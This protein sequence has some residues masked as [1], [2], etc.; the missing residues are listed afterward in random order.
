MVLGAALLAAGGVAE[1]SSLWRQLPLAA[2]HGQ[3]APAIAR[4]QL[5]A[6]W[7]VVLA[8]GRPATL[9]LRL[10]EPGLLKGI[11]LRLGRLPAGVTGRIAVSADGRR[12]DT[13]YY[14]AGP[15]PAG[16]TGVLLDT[17][18]EGPHVRLIFQGPPWGATP[19]QVEAVE[20]FADG[21]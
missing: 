21:G 12:Y 2:A 4:G 19:I 13:V 5:A 9:D 6:P 16:Q 10:A 15:A 11:R 3:G 7:R 1:A 18:R 17:W 14:F 20:A 8:P